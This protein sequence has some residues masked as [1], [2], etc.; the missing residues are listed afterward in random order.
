[1]VTKVVPRTAAQ[2]RR[3][4]RRRLTL[5]AVVCIVMVLAGMGFGS[6][7]RWLL[8]ADRLFGWLGGPG[9]LSKTENVLI[10]GV[11]DSYDADGHRQTQKNRRVRTDTI[12]VA[13]IQP[14]KNAIHVLSIPRDTQVLIPGYG[15]EKINAAHAIGG[16]ERTKAT[17]EAVTGIPIH[18]T[19]S[20]SLLGAVSFL[21]ELGGIDLYVEQDMKYTDRTAG[22]FI[23]LKQG[24][25]HFD[26]KTAIGYARFRHDAMGDIGRVSRQQR[27]LNAVERKLMTPAVWW[28]LPRLAEASSKLFQTDIPAAKLASLAN[29][30][31]EKP[32]VSFTTLPGTFGYNGYWVA[33]RGRLDELVANLN[34]KSSKKSDHRTVELLY[35]TSQSDAAVKLASTLTDRGLQVIRTE[36]L[37]NETQGTRVIGRNGDPHQPNEL[38]NLLPN[39]PWQLSDDIT[40]YSVDYTVVVGKDFGK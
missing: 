15:T 27:L 30:A 22:L 11:D 2:R 32:G 36:P 26:G 20:V 18:H 29:F 24:M 23:D 1:M 25:Q 8:P 4:T 3:F 5:L 35:A 34:E 33:D 37:D 10:V 6:L 14:R 16:I 9:S 21:D 40:P 31:K 7:A 38:R 12:L 19:V 28:R 39:A 13:T 17:V